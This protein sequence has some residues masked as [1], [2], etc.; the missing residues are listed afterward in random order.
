MLTR[1]HKAG[2]ER[3]HFVMSAVQ[4]SAVLGVS[5]MLGERCESLEVCPD[6]YLATNTEM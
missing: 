4:Y 1:R 6:S 5:D 3:L 2:D